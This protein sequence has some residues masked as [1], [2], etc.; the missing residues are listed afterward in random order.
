MNFQYKAVSHKQWQCDLCNHS[1][2]TMLSIYPTGLL[3]VSQNVPIS[4]PVFPPSPYGGLLLILQVSAP[5][6]LPREAFP[7]HT[8]AH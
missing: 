6:H 3:P 5:G 2:L 4:G 8:A 1:S 7:D